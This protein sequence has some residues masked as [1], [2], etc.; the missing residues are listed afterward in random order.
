MQQNH[1]WLANSHTL[2]KLLVVAITP[3]SWQVIHQFLNLN[4]L[5]CDNLFTASLYLVF[6]YRFWRALYL[7]FKWK[8]LPWHWVSFL[9]LELVTQSFSC[10]TFPFLFFPH[11]NVLIHHHF[12]LVPQMSFIYLKRLKGHSWSLL[13]A[14]FLVVGSI[15]QLFLVS[16]C[17]HRKEKKYTLPLSTSFLLN[18]YEGRL[19][20]S[21]YY[22]RI[23]SSRQRKWLQKI[24]RVR[25]SP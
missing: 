18:W 12:F 7:G 2:K 21:F 14:R 23:I 25:V 5:I 8:W 24:W 22:K 10:S 1:R 16:S 19:F 9:Y 3:V 15:Q 13:L 6:L 11:S 4:V 20:F 17:L